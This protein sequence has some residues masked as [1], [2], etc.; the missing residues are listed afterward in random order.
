MVENIEKYPKLPI[1]RLAVIITGEESKEEQLQTSV[2]EKIHVKVH[3]ELSKWRL[4]TKIII[5]PKINIWHVQFEFVCK[6][7]N[8][9]SKALRE[10]I[11]Y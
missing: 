5:F 9:G 8:F 10:V 11:K 3:Y 4:S 2:K 7:N 6:A 1:L